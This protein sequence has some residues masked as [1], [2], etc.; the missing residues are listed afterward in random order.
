VRQ[1]EEVDPKYKMAI[2]RET[3]EAEIETEV[4]EIEIEVTEIEIETE[5]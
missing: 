2:E 3:E 1:K 5:R 4:T